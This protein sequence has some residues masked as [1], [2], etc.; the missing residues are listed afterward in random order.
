MNGLSGDCLDLDNWVMVTVGDWSEDIKVDY[1]MFKDDVKKVEDGY[2]MKSL[3]KITDVR[4]NNEDS[5][6]STFEETF[7]TILLK[8]PESK[9]WERDVM[10]NPYT[11]TRSYMKDNCNFSWMN[12]I[13]FHFF[14]NDSG[15]WELL[16]TEIK[17][18]MY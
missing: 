9:H 16:S 17:K 2:K 10:V 13:P 5:W 7:N 3:L 18:M 15:K 4:R 12:D 1:W 11:N 8:G 6:F 14:N